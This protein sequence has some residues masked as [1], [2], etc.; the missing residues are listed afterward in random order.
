MSSSTE[1]PF[2]AMSASDVSTVVLPGVPLRGAQAGTVR[3]AGIGQ[4]LTAPVLSPDQAREAA[5]SEGYAVGWAAGM[6]EAAAAVQAQVLAAQ[7]EHAAVRA[8][9]A[10]RVEAALGALER[11]GVELA[12][13]ALPLVE[14]VADA[15]TAGGYAVAEAVVGRELQQVAPGPDAVRR[16]LAQAPTGRPVL[17]RL[18]PEDVE[19]VLALGDELVGGREVQLVADP[20]LRSGDAVAECDYTTIDARIGHALARVKEILAP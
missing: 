18:A 8:A 19:A 9:Y 12:T 2:V 3:S 4:R 17:V 16:V 1:Q 14:E 5:R 10:A 13:R 20:S 15:I 6:R 7:Q 11:A